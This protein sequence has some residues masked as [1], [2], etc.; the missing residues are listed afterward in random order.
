MDVAALSTSLTGGAVASQVDT[1]VLKALQNL[2]K[3]VAATL[4]AG[5]GLGQS[6]DAY[7]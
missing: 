5:I 1:S 3:S 7:A 4:F 2:D 6:V